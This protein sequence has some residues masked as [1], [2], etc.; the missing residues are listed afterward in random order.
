MRVK[1]TLYLFGQKMESE[2]ETLEDVFN[3]LKGFVSLHRDGAIID[4]E[5][6]IYK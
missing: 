3:S 1:V 6:R 5:M 4:V 2:V